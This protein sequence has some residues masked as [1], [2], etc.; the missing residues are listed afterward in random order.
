MATVRWRPQ[1]LDD[2][3][4]IRR[5]IARD[6]PARAASFVA[7]LR[8]K[9]ALLAEHPEIGRAAGPG[10]PTNMRMLVLHR[11]YL[12]YYRLMPGEDQSQAVEVLRVKHARM[13]SGASG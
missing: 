5:F 8:E 3:L 10:L 4:A 2:L 11:N 1:A 9:A 13:K 12:A 6:N 7:E